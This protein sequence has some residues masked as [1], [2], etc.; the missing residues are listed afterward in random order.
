[1]YDGPD[2]ED[3]HLQMGLRYHGMRKPSQILDA[4]GP[5]LDYATDQAVEG[6]SD[7]METEFAKIQCQAMQMFCKSNPDFDLVIPHEDEGDDYLDGEPA[8]IVIVDYVTKMFE[9]LSEYTLPFTRYGWA[10]EDPEND[11][12]C[13]LG[14]WPD[15]DD[16]NKAVENKRLAEVDSY[17][18]LAEDQAEIKS[19]GFLYAIMID[20]DDTIIFDVNDLTVVWQY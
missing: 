13:A 5:D 15:W 7:W 2:F 17:E 10:S 11:G 9:T 1:M 20:G 18:Q 8:Y 3:E 19:L 16:V 6:G 4:I 12:Y 14:V